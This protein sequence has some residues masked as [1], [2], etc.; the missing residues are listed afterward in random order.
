[1]L[2]LLGASDSL[3]QESGQP[4]VYLRPATAV[5]VSPESERQ[6]H[7]AFENLYNLEFTAS[8][9]VFGEVAK[10]EPESATVRAFW[11]SA[12]LYEILARQGSLQ[13]QLFVT[14]NDFLRF[15]RLP[16][17]P[18]LKKEFEQRIAEAQQVAEKRLRRDPQDVDG[19]FALGLSY[20]NQAN[21]LAGAEGKYLA[22]LRMGERAFTI[23]HKLRQLR[24]ELHDS[25]VVL[26]VHD[27]VI[28][29]LPRTHRLFLFFVGARGSRE[30]GLAYLEEAAKN[31]EYL[32]TYAEVLLVVAHIRAG[33]LDRALP[34]AIDLRH[35]Y[36]QNPIFTLE[37]AKLHRQ[38]KLYPEARQVVSELLAEVMAHPHNP[39]IIGPEDALFELALLEAAEGKPER[40]LETFER[41]ESVSHANKRVVALAILE[42]GKLYDQLGQRDHALAEY[43]RVLHLGADRET[44]KRARLYQK[45][46]YVES[47]LNP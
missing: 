22:G 13:S 35:R 23:H 32:R 12:L 46:P 27:Y 17:D 39:R 30:R 1:L 18:E 47:G 8:H 20:G 4:A 37:V 42:R 24:P 36:P 10:A 15:E 31:G 26:G 3:P 33:D 2:V 38:Q 41:V 19:L 43:A 21:Y 6:L 45:R 16:P 5:A 29:N 14:T 9:Q 25:A 44:S 40:A 28:G 7:R 34:L 11:A